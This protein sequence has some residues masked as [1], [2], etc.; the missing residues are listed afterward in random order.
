MGGPQSELDFQED[1]PLTLA[2]APS[3]SVGGGGIFTIV[4]GVQD[5]AESGP[6]FRVGPRDLIIVTILDINTSTCYISTTG[7]DAAKSGGPRIPFVFALTTPATAQ[8]GPRYVK[9]IHNL[10]ELWMYSGVQGEGVTIEVQ[11]GGG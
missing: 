9:G 5:R 4:R 11:L 1:A 7:P 8:P 6:A 2:A 10:N 3:A